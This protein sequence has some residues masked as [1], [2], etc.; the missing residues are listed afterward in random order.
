MNGTKG[1]SFRNFLVEARDEAGTVEYFA[2]LKWKHA[3]AIID[4]ANVQELRTQKLRALE[5]RERAAKPG[6]GQPGGY[7]EDVLRF[8]RTGKKVTP[9]SVAA[10]PSERYPGASDNAKS[11][12]TCLRH[13]YSSHEFSGSADAR[14]GAA[15]ELAVH[16][17]RG[18]L[19]GQR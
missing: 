14:E 6:G 9:D 8:S 4:T 7:G 16:L 10:W 5:A 1:G 13:I 18:K 11:L 12:E 15:V 17:R 3:K 2:G 19:K